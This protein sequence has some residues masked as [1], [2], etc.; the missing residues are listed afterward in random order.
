M[1]DDVNFL[2]GRW[3]SRDVRRWNS[4]TVDGNSSAPKSLSAYVLLHV[5]FIYTARILVI[6]MPFY[7]TASQ[8]DLH[9]K[10][11]IDTT[12]ISIA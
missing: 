12:T 4:S 8:D 2:A 1:K 3:V 9:S 10:E 6:L 11:I 5:R 7:L